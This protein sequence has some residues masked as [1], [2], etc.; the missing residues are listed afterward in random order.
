MSP[1]DTPAS[2]GNY[3]GLHRETTLCDYIDTHAYR[4][5]LLEPAP[6]QSVC[7]L[8]L[9]YLRESLQSSWPPQTPGPWPT[10]RDGRSCSR[11]S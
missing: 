5:Q 2:Y 4:Q 8:P 10:P 1:V 3:W 6:Y 9:A 11:R 7:E